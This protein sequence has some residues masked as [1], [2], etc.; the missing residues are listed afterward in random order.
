M[1]IFL[2]LIL[3]II[4]IAAP[5]QHF[6]DVISSLRDPR[7]STDHQKCFVSTLVGKTVRALEEVSIQLSPILLHLAGSPIID[8]DK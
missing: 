8:F 2:Y 3:F 6:D 7:L 4:L 1:L 5:P